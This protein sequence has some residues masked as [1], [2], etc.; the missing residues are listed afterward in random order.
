MLNGPINYHDF[1]DYDANTGIFVWKAR[2]GARSPIGAI[3][4]S[5]TRKGYWVIQIKG[6]V[7]QAHRLAWLLFYGA[8]PKQQIDHINGY[9]NDNR[10]VNLRDVDGS[11]NL[12][13]QRKAR[14]DNKKSTLL[15]VA[16]HKYSGLWRARIKLHG[17]DYHIGLYHTP[18]AAQV[19]YLERKR[20]LHPGCT[21]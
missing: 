2:L 18:E 11:T 12:Q 7:I 14:G 16:W 13:N 3:A 10:I 8:W 15:G 17:K 1:L 4:G 21:I 20:Q 6:K 5:L 19:A 9:K